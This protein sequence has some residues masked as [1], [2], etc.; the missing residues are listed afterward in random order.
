MSMAILLMR[1]WEASIHPSRGAEGFVL[2]GLTSEKKQ[3]MI[4]RLLI[5]D[6]T[7]KRASKR[8]G[9]HRRTAQSRREDANDTDQIKELPHKT[10]Y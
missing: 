10:P 5:S 7:A 3:Q 8:K 4:S 2:K 6:F 9:T 1:Q